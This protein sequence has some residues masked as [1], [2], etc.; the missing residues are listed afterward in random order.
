MKNLYVTMF[1]KKYRTVGST[2]VAL[3]FFVVICAIFLFV[4]YIALFGIKTVTFDSWILGIIAFLV[5][6]LEV[7]IEGKAYTLLPK[8]IRN[9]AFTGFFIYGFFI[10]FLV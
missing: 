7:T 1:G 6:F 9:G 10:K 3:S 2:P 8:L 4:T 5:L